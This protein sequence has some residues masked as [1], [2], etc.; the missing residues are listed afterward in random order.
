MER[1]RVV[2]VIDGDSF[3]TKDGRRIRLLGIDAPEKDKC[4]YK[5]ARERL[6]GLLLGK[7]VRLKNT[8]T[9]DYGRLLANVVA[10]DFPTWIKYMGWWMKKYIGGIENNKEKAKI[11]PMANRMMVREGLARFTYVKSPYIE[12]LKQAQQEARIKQKGIYSSLCRTQSPNI[13]CMIKGNIR[14]GK[15]KVYHLPDCPNYDQVIIDESYGD[16]W[17]CQE[18]EAQKEGFRKAEGC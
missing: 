5:E 12:E 14:E 17:F 8:V 4:M 1:S 15:K 11:D 18:A 7:R 10:E 9:D 6:T 13:D 16:Q 2:K 3:Q